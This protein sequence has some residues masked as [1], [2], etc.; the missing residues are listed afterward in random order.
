MAPN[1]VSD[2]DACRQRRR[3]CEKPA[4]A[5]EAVGPEW[6]AEQ[7]LAK[8]IE[9]SLLP[10]SL[11][12]EPMQLRR[13]RSSRKSEDAGPG[14]EQAAAAAAATCAAVGAGAGPAS[15]LDSK[16][17]SRVRRLNC[18]SAPLA[19]MSFESFIV[20]SQR[21]SNSFTPTTSLPKCLRNITERER[22]AERCGCS[23]KAAEGDSACSV[24]CLTR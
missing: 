6:Y 14:A 15:A 1:T 21:C 2:L 18:C 16:G 8:R 12:S 4:R 10:S 9:A 13:A 11:S 17:S 24:L 7:R 5:P 20:G 22:E 19:C 23:C 3:K